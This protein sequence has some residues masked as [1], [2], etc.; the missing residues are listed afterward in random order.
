LRREGGMRERK[1]QKENRNGNY[2]IKKVK[3]K[4][5]IIVKGEKKGVHFD[6]PDL[7]AAYWY[8]ARMK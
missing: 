5:R 6:L 2:V 7:Y 8:P 1:F 4:I 3:K